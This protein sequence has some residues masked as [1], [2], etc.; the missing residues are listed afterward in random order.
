VI[1]ITVKRQNYILTLH[2]GREEKEDQEEKNKII[3]LIIILTEK[4]DS[5]NTRILTSNSKA[6]YSTFMD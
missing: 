4:N 5:Y 2:S 3:I 6:I 1:F